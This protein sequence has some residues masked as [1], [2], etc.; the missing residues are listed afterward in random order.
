MSTIFSSETETR[1]GSGFSFHR[2]SGIM[3][4]QAYLYKRTLHRWLEILYWPTVDVMLWGFITLYL[5]RTTSDISSVAPRILGALILWDIMFRAQQSVAV[6]FLEDMWGRN[7]LNIWASPIKASEYIAGT[8]LI[9]VVR[10]AIGAGVAILLGVLLYNFNFFTIGLS[11][12]PFVLALAVM[13]WSIGV[14]TTAVVL[15]LGQGAE[16]LAW[17]IA[18]LFQPFSA[19]FYPVSVL[20]G[21]MQA[22]ARCIPA[23]Y[24][25]EGMRRILEPSGGFPTA[26]LVKG[27]AV[28]A[29]Y[30]VGAWALFAW[31]LRQVRD[32]GLLSRFGE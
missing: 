4:R 16:E 6:G 27:F 11:L 26:L 28:D 8:I 7:V 12:V 20:P 2:V 5:Q 22:I 15:R 9:G 13:G 32:R 29:V 10:V 30:V 19:V 1:R 24:I 18:F 23:S 17:A 25:F 14:V 21:W 31:M 3:L